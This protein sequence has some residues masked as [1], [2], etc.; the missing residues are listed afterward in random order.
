MAGDGYIQHGDIVLSLKS[1]CDRRKLT[2]VTW[3]IPYSITS[4]T[5]G[6]IGHGGY[7]ACRPVDV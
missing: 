3:E 4:S 7:D 1:H 5:H 6:I 2:D